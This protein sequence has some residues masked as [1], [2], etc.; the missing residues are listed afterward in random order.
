MPRA[1]AQYVCTTAAQSGVLP[2][3]PGLQA[4]ERQGEPGLV[5]LKPQLSSASGED[6]GDGCGDGS[7][8]G[9]GDGWGD[10]EGDACAPLQTVLTLLVSSV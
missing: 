6:D 4:A 3:A 1:D 5:R 7:G 2:P 9:C 10:G 8:E